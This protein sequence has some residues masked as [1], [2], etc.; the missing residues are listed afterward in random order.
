M[1]SAMASFIII[2]GGQSVGSYLLQC[3]VDEIQVVEFEYGFGKC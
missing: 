1:P 2:S 3:D